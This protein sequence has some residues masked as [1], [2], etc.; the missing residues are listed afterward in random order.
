VGQPETQEVKASVKDFPLITAGVIGASLF[1]FC[2]PSVS[3]ILVYRSGLEKSGEVWRL[4]TGHF[5][6]FSLSHLGYNLLAFGLIGYVLE[7]RNR[8]RYASLCILSAITITLFFLL[9]R[10]SLVEYGG[11]SGLITAATVYLCLESI[12]RA[13][14]PRPLW[15]LL[16]ALLAGKI[17]Y[18]VVTTT[19]VFVDC[20]GG[21]FSVVPSAHVVGGLTALGGYLCTIRRF[22][23]PGTA[24][25]R[26]RPAPE[27][28]ETACR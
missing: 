4:L 10:P 14:P 3:S 23:L 26:R 24:K 2:L 19:A 20:T 21:P 1:A 22:G 12:V 15:F 17:G 18:E 5:V 25:E 11:L 13:D 6:H 16:L 28:V 7:K 8:T 9:F 27:V